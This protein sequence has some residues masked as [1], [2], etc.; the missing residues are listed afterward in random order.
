MLKKLGP[1]LL[2]GGLLTL[3]IGAFLF[4]GFEKIEGRERAVVQDWQKGVLPEL[5]TPGTKFYIP[6]KIGRAHV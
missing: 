2:G 5:V 1:F 4:V 3:L 6:A